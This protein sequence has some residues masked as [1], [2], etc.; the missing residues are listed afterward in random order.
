MIRKPLRLIT[1][2][3]G[4]KHIEWFEK[5]C[6][7][8]LMWPKNAQTVRGATWTFITTQ[9]DQPKI[10]AL[11]SRHDLRLADIEFIVFGPEF[12][13]NPHSAGAFINQA[14]LMEMSRAIMFGAQSFLAPPDT[15]FADGT[16]PNMVQIG[17]Q[18]DSV[19]FAVHARVLPTIAVDSPALS[20]AQLVS[21]AWKSLHKTWSAA[22]IGLDKINSYVGGVSWRYLDVSLYSV[23]HRLPTPYLINFTPEDL[24]FFKNQIHWGVIDH[25]WPSAGLVET[26]RVRLLGSSDAGFMVEVTE[27]EQNIPPEAAYREDEPDL[28]WKNLQHNKLNRMFSVILRG[29]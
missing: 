20:P 4:A 15:I 2:V 5:Y 18:R 7:N 11:I 29:E 22:E 6:L 24:V 12:H 25:A 9:E 27:P 23:C 1:T 19:V 13:Q 10:Q 3:W 28:F 14:L 16:L 8:S 26:E 17:A 21:V